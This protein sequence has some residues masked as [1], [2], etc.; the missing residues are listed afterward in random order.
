[1]LRW[2]VSIDVWVYNLSQVSYQLG[3]TLTISSPYKSI[4]IQFR[5]FPLNCLSKVTIHLQYTIHHPRYPHAPQPQPQP[6]PPTPDNPKPRPTT[7]KA[8]NYRPMP[9]TY[10]QWPSPHG[11]RYMPIAN[12]NGLERVRE[13]ERDTVSDARENV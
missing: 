11:Q 3:S 2:Q 10:S 6:Q 8:N 5:N 12:A 7:P 4:H 1:M 13:R 9:T